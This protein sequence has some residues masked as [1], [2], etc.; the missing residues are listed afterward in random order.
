LK[1]AAYKPKNPYT[2]QEKPVKKGE[3]KTPRKHT[4]KL[5]NNIP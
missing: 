3:N 4:T 1:A 5:H 2:R